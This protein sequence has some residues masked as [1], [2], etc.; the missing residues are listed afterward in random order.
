MVPP[1][2]GPQPAPSMQVR[3]P[4]SSETEAR[5]R[6]V[7]DLLDENERALISYAARRLGG[8]VE[9]A[10]DVVQEAFLRLCREASLEGRGREWLFKVTRNLCI[11]VQ[12]KE[13]RMT[14][15]DDVAA[16]DAPPDHVEPQA[17]ERAVDSREDLA[18]EIDRLPGRQ[19][20]ALR[21]KFESGLS[22]AEIARVMETSAGTVG[23]LLHTAI[24]GLRARMAPEGGVR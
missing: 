18:S 9:R 17:P 15:W 1:E 14:G 12:R 7:E 2:A 4:G 11:D 23:W 13:S 20:E 8:D 10:R 16:A 19:Q 21:L 5:A 24:H 6:T 3:P 22:Y